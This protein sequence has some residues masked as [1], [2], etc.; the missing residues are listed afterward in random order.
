MDGQRFDELARLVASG[1]P[2]RRV[3][4][5]IGGG[6]AALAAKAMPARAGCFEEGGGCEIQDDC[7]TGLF[8]VNNVCTGPV[9]I[10][11][12]E[13]C[14]VPAG[15]IPTECCS[16]SECIEGICTPVIPPCSEVG[17]PCVVTQGVQQTCCGDLVCVD[18]TCQ[19]AC[20]AEGAG[21]KSDLDCCD[22]LVC[23]EGT[24]V[25][26]EPV[27][28]VEGEACSNI[29]GVAISCCEELECVDGTCTVVVE[30]VAEGEACEV[31]GDCCT[32]I[33]CGGACRDIECCI[34]DPNPND[35][36][37]DGQACFEGVCEGVSTGC[38][39]D[40]GCGTGTCCCDDASCSA[41]CCPDDPVTQLPDTGAG[42]G[43]GRASGWFGAAIAGAAAAFLGGR[44]LREQPQPVEIDE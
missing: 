26:P 38:S 31:D 41:D 27:C 13:S 28:A 36:C 18:S 6:L 17:E 35:R 10:P 42:L 40:S 22:G 12:G 1:V 29:D 37:D 34:D 7:C 14:I 39:D 4:G 25:P 8:C 19:V 16:G 43:Q 24:C 44:K 20:Q 9:C 11:D 23:P 3:L 15:Q 33:C 30:C 2:R 32:G 21:C 5:M